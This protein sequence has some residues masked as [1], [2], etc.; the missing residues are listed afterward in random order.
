MDGSAKLRNI[1]KPPSTINVHSIECISH[2]ER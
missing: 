1:I 2:Y